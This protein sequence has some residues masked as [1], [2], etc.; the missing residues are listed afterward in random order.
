MT[1]GVNG[2]FITKL[3]FRVEVIDYQALCDIWKDYS[4]GASSLVTDVS[5]FLIRHHVI[6]NI[7]IIL[8]SKHNVGQS[9]MS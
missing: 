2:V 6:L 3:C 7:S 1:V 4:S 5:R 9:D 8:H